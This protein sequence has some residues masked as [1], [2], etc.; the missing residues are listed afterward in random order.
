MFSLFKREG[1][2][3]IEDSSQKPVICMVALKE[4]KDLK[5]DELLKLYYEIRN[6]N[7]IANIEE[8]NGTYIFDINGDMG[9]ISFMPAP[10][11]WNDLDGPCATAWYWP[12]ATNVMKSHSA[13]VIISIIP[14]NGHINIINRIIEVT[15]IAASVAQSLDALGVYW[16]SGTVVNEKEL[17]IEETKK[18]NS[19]YFP[20]NLWIDFRI[21]SMNGLT[22]IITTGMNAFGHKE[23][24]II[25]SRV[26]ATELLNFTYNIASY[27]I[28]KGP[29]VKDGDTVG[30]DE[31]KRIKVKFR[32]SVW[33]REG[34]VMG[35]LYE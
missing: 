28:E 15:C 2:K 18:I 35:I 8:K 23:I 13:H 14:K 9:L 5:H 4:M 6:P 19:D 25:K 17:F 11:P 21:Q 27:L 7:S 22:N 33:K 1:T 20:L 24:E 30:D 31:K 12:E 34:S 3:S 10:I 16:G 26:K 29:V 32:P